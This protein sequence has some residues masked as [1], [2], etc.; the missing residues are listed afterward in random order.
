MQPVGLK[1]KRNV[2]LLLSVSFLPCFL[3]YGIT[4]Q[5]PQK[6]ETAVMAETDAKEVAETG[7]DTEAAK[8]KAQLSGMF[9]ALSD[10]GTDR[11][12]GQQRIT[13]RSGS[14]IRKRCTCS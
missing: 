11:E 12:P 1:I 6:E 9:R 5:M 2:A 3:A 4:P 7:A 10:R 8:R 14:P 13:G